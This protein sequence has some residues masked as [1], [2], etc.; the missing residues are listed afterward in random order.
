MSYVFMCSILE[1]YVSEIKCRKGK[2]DA[3][4]IQTTVTLGREK[5][6]E[7]VWEGQQSAQM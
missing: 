5:K 4:R 6:G 7:E 2:I 3:Y 1:L